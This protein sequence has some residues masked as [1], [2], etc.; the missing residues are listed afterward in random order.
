MFILWDRAS[1]AKNKRTWPSLYPAPP[2]RKLALLQPAPAPH[3]RA[4]PP[5]APCG[6]RAAARPCAALASPLLSEPP[7]GGGTRAAAPPTCSRAA[8]LPCAAVRSS[9]RRPKPRRLVPLHPVHRALSSMPPPELV[10][11]PSAPEM[12]AH[13]GARC[14]RT[15]T[16]RSARFCGI[17]SSRI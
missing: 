11:E 14:H 5:P 16:A 10:P 17:E 8:A 9:R 4:L 15:W 2:P 1:S 12:P 7:R 6:A 13:H 3:R